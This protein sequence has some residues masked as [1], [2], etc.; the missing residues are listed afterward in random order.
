MFECQILECLDHFRIILRRP[1]IILR[2]RQRCDFT[3]PAH[4]NLSFHH[5]FFRQL[6]FG[7]RA[8][9]FFVKRSLRISLSMARLAY[10]FL[11]LEFSSSR[12][13]IRLHQKLPYHRTCSSSCKMLLLKC[14]VPCRSPWCCDPLLVV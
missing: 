12:S 4:S 14:H 3:G 1:E 7:G 13:F 10:I 2:T 9:P 11:S 8:Q 6:P 5:Y